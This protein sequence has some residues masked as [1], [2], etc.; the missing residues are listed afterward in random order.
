MVTAPAMRRRRPPSS[1]SPPAVGQPPRDPVGV[2]D[3]HGGD[4]GRPLRAVPQPVGDALAVGDLPDARTRGPSAPAPA[5][6]RPARRAPGSAPRRR[7][8]ARTAPCR[9]GP[10]GGP[11]WRPSW[12]RGRSAAA[13]RARPAP[14]S[15]ASN[16]SR[17]TSVK[18][19]AGSSATAKWV[20]DPLQGQLRPLLDGQRQLHRVVR[21][22]AH[23]V[24]PGVDLDVDV[25]RAPDPAGRRGRGRHRG[26]ARLGVQRRRQPEGD[27]VGHGLGGR[28]RQQ[29]HRRVDPG[30]AQLGALLHAGP[31]P[32]TT[33]PR[34]A[35]PA[36]RAPGRGRRPRP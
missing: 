31:P 22:R 33:L 18:G 30:V 23:P 26:H 21:R 10:P 4:R 34:R 7:R 12:R 19:S 24:H 5:A 9:S 28:L 27:H 35:R 11:W 17:C 3:G 6:G 14:R 8:P 2:P 15:T 36:P 32:A 29:Q 20:H 1:T 16:R 13:T 25:E